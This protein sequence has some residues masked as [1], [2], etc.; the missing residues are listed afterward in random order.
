MSIPVPGV[1][2]VHL[3][4]TPKPGKSKKIYTDDFMLSSDKDGE[5]SGPFSPSQIAGNSTLTVVETPGTYIGAQN[6]GPVWGGI[7]GTG[8][9]M[10]RLPG[11][12]GGMGTSPG[13]TEASAKIDAEDPEKTGGKKP[14]PLLDALRAKVLTGGVVDA[15]REGF[16][17]FPLDGKH[18]PKQIELIYGN[19]RT[20]QMRLRFAD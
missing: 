12:G 11:N 16:L 2:V 13:V 15:P 9:P 6:T 8:G 19:K 14:N 17:Y 10:G 20:G 1:V 5:H 4:L 3:K 18:K 7:P